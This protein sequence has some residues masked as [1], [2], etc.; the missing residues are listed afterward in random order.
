MVQAQVVNENLKTDTQVKHNIYKQ[1][2]QMK[3][4]FFRVHGLY[5]GVTIAFVFNHVII[6]D[7]IIE[8]VYKL[9]FY[10]LLW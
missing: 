3:L 1:H 8:M 10:V 7:L 2:N 6:I 9:I 4:F 5:F